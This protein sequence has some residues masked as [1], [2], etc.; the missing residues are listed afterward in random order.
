MTSSAK[1]ADL[2]LQYL[3]TTEQEDIVPNDYAGNMGYL[4]FGQPATSAKF[5][6]RSLYWMTSEIARLLGDDVLQ[7][8]TEGRSQSEWLHYLYAKMR[9]RDPDG[10]FV[11]RQFRED[12]AGHP[13]KTPSGKI[14]IYSAR[15]A[16]IAV[17]WQLQQGDTITPLPQYVSTFEGWDDPLRTRF[18]LQL[19]GFHY[20]ARTHS[21]YGNIDVLQAACQQDIWIN[22]LDARSREIK[23]GDWVRVFNDRGEVHILAKVT[24]RILPGVT[25]IVQGAWPI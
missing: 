5:E 9:A 10:H 2:L 1:Y 15:L 25:A 20:K 17:R 4:I 19:A 23:N 18:P 7:R 8:F 16:D 22:P 12:H 6:H 24:P 11:A 21:S 13:L 14:E 3:M